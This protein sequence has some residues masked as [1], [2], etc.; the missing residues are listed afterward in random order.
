MVFRSIHN[1]EGEPISSSITFLNLGA[2]HD[3]RNF[4]SKHDQT[5]WKK[6]LGEAK[7]RT[8]KKFRWLSNT[9]A[10][11][12]VRLKKRSVWKKFFF[13]RNRDK[14]PSLSSHAPVGHV[15]DFVDSDDPVLGRVGLLHDVQ[16]EVLVAD[17]GVADAVVA[18]WLAWKRRKRYSN[19]G[20][21]IAGRMVY[22]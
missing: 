10:M 12:I 3:F 18:R 22:L 11:N 1:S 9:R 8:S 14:R 4:S 20:L 6:N 15:L 16:L 7:K 21:W 13:H 2:N 5:H 17:F 19:L